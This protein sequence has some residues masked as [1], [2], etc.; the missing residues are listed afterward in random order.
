M[1]DE[2]FVLFT[3]GSNKIHSANYNELI[4]DNEFNLNN[5]CGYGHGVSGQG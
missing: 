2:L 5:T 3:Y 4:I 1:H